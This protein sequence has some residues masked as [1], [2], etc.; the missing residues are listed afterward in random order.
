ML[1]LP[2]GSELVPGSRL[3]VLDR[4][5][6]DVPPG[7]RVAIV[8]PSG[9]GKS[10]LAWL[11]LR[12]WEYEQGQIYLGGHELRRYH[13]DDARRMISMVSQDTHLFNGTIGENLLI[14]RPSAAPQEL[15][16]AAEQAQLLPFI[17]GLPRGYDTWVGEQGL[18]LSGGERQRLALARAFLKDAPILILDEPIAQ[19]DAA[20]A[21]AFLHALDRL[22]LGRTTLMITHWLAG[23][24]MFDNILVLDGG[25]VVEQG[26]HHDLLA[27]RGRYWH[28]QEPPSPG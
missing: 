14:A 2:R 10:T 15:D 20:T 7:G 22:M 11:L 18:R 17:R 27:R 3:L 12:F 23:L 6:F 28:M 9:A 13:A 25:R 1:D 19:L 24:E 26:R 5:S 16:T 4:V 8:G 21:R